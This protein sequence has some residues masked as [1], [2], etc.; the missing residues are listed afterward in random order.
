[1]AIIAAGRNLQQLTIFR[2]GSALQHGT[3]TRASAR[4]WALARDLWNHQGYS[5][6]AVQRIVYGLTQPVVTAAAMFVVQFTATTLVGPHLLSYS[7][8]QALQRVT[9]EP[10]RRCLVRRTTASRHGGAYVP[11][12]AIDNTEKSASARKQALD[13]ELVSLIGQASPLM[14]TVA[15]ATGSPLA[16]VCNL[17]TW[18]IL[19]AAGGL[20]SYQRAALL[21]R[22]PMMT[23]PLWKWIVGFH[24]LKGAP[25]LLLFPAGLMTSCAGCAEPRRDC[26]EV[27]PS[28]AQLSRP[29]LCLTERWAARCSVDLAGPISE[30][31]LFRGFLLT[32]LCAKIGAA[33]ALLVSSAAFG[34][35]HWHPDE[36][37]MLPLL[38]TWSG[39]CCGV[40]YLVTGR[41]VVPIAMHA[42]QNVL[43]LALTEFGW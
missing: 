14:E 24:A 32:S 7:R 25:L 16:S 20:A 19:S 41:L 12:A 29:G 35:A 34:A 10:E 37:E 13:P 43:S 36:P 40:A 5:S 3:A 27:E 23:T 42:S 6:S 33:P 17:W 26:S 22:A 4:C 31:L 9:S 2:S 18:F 1:M 28:P 21:R 39:L 38:E 30:E 11:R 15:S 8:L